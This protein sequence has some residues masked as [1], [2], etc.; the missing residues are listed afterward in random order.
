[1]NLSLVDTLA[2]QIS[3]CFSRL[4]CRLDKLSSRIKPQ[5][6]Q[7]NKI[8]LHD[9][10]NAF[11]EGT[12]TL[13]ADSQMHLQGTTA[14]P[15]ALPLLTAV[16]RP[17]H[18]HCPSSYNNAL[19]CAS[20][21]YAVHVQQGSPKWQCADWHC[22]ISLLWCPPATGSRSWTTRPGTSLRMEGS[23]PSRWTPMTTA[24]HT[25]QWWTHSGGQWQ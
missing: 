16:M 2:G 6:K 9:S 12:D 8:Y 17:G 20:H 7:L 14:L 21:Y 24:P 25:S 15:F 3:F 1:M 10:G 19:C 4:P 22:C 18:Q 11:A 23:M 5:C 13:A